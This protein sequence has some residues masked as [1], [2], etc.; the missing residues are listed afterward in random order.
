MVAIK[1][2]LE[3]QLNFSLCEIKS[4]CQISETFRWSPSTTLLLGRLESAYPF[5][6]GDHWIWGQGDGE[7]L[8]LICIS[9]PI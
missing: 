7:P 9:R 6:W 4:F 5:I 1:H 3:A 8:A 2:L